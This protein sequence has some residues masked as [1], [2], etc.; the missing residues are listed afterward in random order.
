MADT[1]VTI[2]LEADKEDALLDDADEDNNQGNK[3]KGSRLRSTVGKVSDEGARKTKGRGF[4]PQQRDVEMSDDRYSGASGRFEVLD[5]E[6]K[7]GPLRCKFR[8][9]IRCVFV[10]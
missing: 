3:N 1:Q 4:Q 2:T 6:G 7:T 8:I 9:T 5:D 10:G